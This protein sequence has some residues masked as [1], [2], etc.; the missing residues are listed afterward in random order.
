MPH[1]RRVRGDICCPAEEKGVPEREQADVADQQVERQREEREAQRLHQ[2]H[3]IDKRRRD[4]ERGRHRH[5]D[6]GLAPGR[7]SR[8]RRADL[9]RDIRHYATL[10]NSPAGRIKRTI[11]MMTKI[12]VFDASGKN[13]F[14]NPS[15]T[16][17]AKP[18]TI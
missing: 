14:V 9:L 12:T 10:P 4:D 2:E 1:L 17:S 13:T 6:S 18:V 16:P 11:A 3:R 8:N 7:A 15:M 5:E